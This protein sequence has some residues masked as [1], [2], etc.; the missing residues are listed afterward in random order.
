MKAEELLQALASIYRTAR[1]NP[2]P[3]LAVF[4]FLLCV[5]L[6]FILSFQ[7][8]PSPHPPIAEG[9]VVDRAIKSPRRVTFVSQIR[10]QEERDLAEARVAPVYHYDSGVYRQQTDAAT[11]A[12]QKIGAIRGLSATSSQDRVDLLRRT[13][14][15]SL[16]TEAVDA[17]FAFDAARWQGTVTATL[18]FLDSTMRGDVTADQVAEIK[19]SLAGRLDPSLTSSQALVASELISSFLKPTMVLDKAATDRAR[20]EARDAVPAVLVTIE[21]GETILRDGDIAKDQDLE[22]LEAAGVLNPQVR[23]EGVLGVALLVTIMTLALGAYIYVAQRWLLLNNRRLLLLVVVIVGCTLAAKLTIPGRDVIAYVFPFAAVPMLVATL[24]SVEV[25]ILVV[26]T[27]AVLLGYVAGNLSGN[28]LELVVVY[29]AAGLAGVVSVRHGDRLSRFFLAGGAAALASFGV[30]LSFRLLIQDYG[31]SS[32]LVYGF[33]SLVHG[34]LAAVLTIGTFT[35]LGHI[36][37]ITT[38][39]HLLELAHPSQPLLRRLLTEAPGTYHHSIIVGNLA[40]RAAEMVEADALLVRVGSYYHDVGKIPRAEFFVENQLSG[41]NVHDHLQ[42]VVSAAIVSSHVKDGI[43]LARRYRLPAR[44]QDF[45]SEHH[46]TRF[47]SFFYHRACQQSG[48]VDERNFR[49]PGP[50][51]R[52]KETAIVML[53][54][55]VEAAVRALAERSPEEIDRLVDEIVAQ[56]LAEGQLDDCQLT[57]KDLQQIR[58]AFKMVLRGVFH[59]RVEYPVIQPVTT[60]AKLSDGR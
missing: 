10:T 21:K 38:A 6:M 23:W 7:F 48:K 1:S 60:P 36:F 49:Y 56:R 12:I 54:D 26:A 13:T 42:P 5:P 55:S 3:R 19:N 22:K 16:S 57:L 43:E 39:F 11:N 34:L 37:G 53:A 50:R 24:I 46:G 45:I 27:L 33:A 44:V 15:L 40:E 47:V 51:P 28:S 52:S 17:L 4:V 25:A 35:V 41:E 2:L 8:L 31:I 59:P 9:Q 14:D 30:Y 58:E 29:L 20:K 32:T 18:Q